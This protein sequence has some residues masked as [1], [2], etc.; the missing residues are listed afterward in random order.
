MAQSGWRQW[1]EKEARK[2]LARWRRSG[3]SAKKFAR[4][5]GFSAHRLQYWVKRLGSEGTVKFVP[6]PV[7]E[8]GVLSNSAPI[9]TG[10]IEIEHGGVKVRV[11]EDLDVE[12]IGQLCAALARV[13]RPC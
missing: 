8:V 6:V 12:R 3:L 7:P 4:E 9:G 13:E 5:Q 11:R 1:D 2:V 10:L